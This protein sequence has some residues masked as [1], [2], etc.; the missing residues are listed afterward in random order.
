M[1]KWLLDSV[2]EGEMFGERMETRVMQKVS[3]G[4]KAIYRE[5]EKISFLRFFVLVSDSFAHEYA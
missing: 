1:S 3:A 4:V 5:R 2:K